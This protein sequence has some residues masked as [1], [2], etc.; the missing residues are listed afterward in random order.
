MND[1]EEQ[2]H[3]IKGASPEDDHEIAQV[4][5]SLKEAR[6]AASSWSEDRMEEA[7]ARVYFDEAYGGSTDPLESKSRLFGARYLLVDPGRT[8]A[9]FRVEK[10]LAEHADKGFHA[11]YS[12]DNFEAALKFL[13]S[14]DEGDFLV[15]MHKKRDYPVLICGEKWGVL[16]APRVTDREPDDVPPGEELTVLRE[17]VAA[18]EARLDHALSC[19]DRSC[20]SCADA[21]TTR[22]A[23]KKS[24]GG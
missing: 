19:V 23:R 10:A 5:E 14:V 1:D 21:I 15:T 8:V 12:H 20:R 24:E 16:V 17:K 22:A 6:A 18:L 11:R 2:E 7:R 13:R 9:L 3:G 4:M